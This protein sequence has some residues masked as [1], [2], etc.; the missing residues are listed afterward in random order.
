M[1]AIEGADASE[2]VDGSGVEVDVVAGDGE[3]LAVGGAEGDGVGELYGADEAGVDVGGVEEAGGG[4]A[5]AQDEC[6][7]LEA[8][9][10]VVEEV[11]DAGPEEDAD[12]VAEDAADDGG[13]GA[14]EGESEP[15]FGVAQGEG[16]EQDVRGYGEEGGFGEGEEEEGGCAVGGVGPV[17]DPV[18]ESSVEVPAGDGLWAVGRGCGGVGGGL[19]DGVGGHVFLAG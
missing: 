17:E 9:D 4:C 16:S 12:G 10:V 7:T 15:F 13:E 11:A 18:V 1:L 3:G 5:V 8:G 2:G 6:V 14:G 19:V